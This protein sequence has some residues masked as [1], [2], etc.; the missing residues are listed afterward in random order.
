MVRT[1]ILVHCVSEI[2]ALG[3]YLY[4][5]T[6]RRFLTKVL[7]IIDSTKLIVEGSAHCIC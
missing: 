5:H 4:A 1:E 7:V 2:R 3:N 6:R